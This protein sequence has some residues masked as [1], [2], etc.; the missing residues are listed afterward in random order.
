LLHT[1]LVPLLHPLPLANEVSLSQR[2]ILT[3]Q[4]LTLC[5]LAT[6]AFLGHASTPRAH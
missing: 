2:G 1:D 6:D 5:S 3:L 4:K